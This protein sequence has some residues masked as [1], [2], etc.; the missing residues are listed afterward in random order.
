MIIHDRYRSDEF[1]GAKLPKLKGHV[2]VSLHNCRTGKNEVWEGDN[3]VTNAVRD[4]FAL[5][6]LGGIDHSKLLPLYQSYFG[7]I[8]CYDTLHTLNAD[9]YY[10]QAGHGLV[11]H[12]GDIAPSTAA[13]IQED[14]TRGAPLSVDVSNDNSVTMTWEWGSEQGN[15][16]INS[17]SLTHKDTGNAGLGVNSSAF[18]AFN[19]YLDITSASLTALPLSLNGANNV[20]LKYDDAHCLYFHIGEPSDYYNNHT[21]FA[22]QKITVYKRNLAF[23]KAGLYQNINPS[24]AHEDS[25]TVTTSVN[26]YANPA[27][28]FDYTN[29]KLWLFTN[30]TGA[31]NGYDGTPYSS[32]VVYYSVIDCVNKTEDSHGTITSDTADLAPLCWGADTAFSWDDSRRYMTNLIKQGNYVFFPKTTGI[33][34]NAGAA[35]M[36]WK[37]YRAINI[38][39]SQTYKDISFSDTLVYPACMGMDGGGLIVSPGRII[40]GTTGYTCTSPFTAPSDPQTASQSSS[41]SFATPDKPSS[42]VMAIG[43]GNEGS[44]RPRYIFANKMLNTTLFNLDSPVVKNTSKSLNI[45]YTLTEA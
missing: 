12:A 39:N 13:I 4:I 26:F 45:Q 6:F 22:T 2:K 36:N 17:I 29:K 7:G 21:S 42:F 14:L 5:N 31:A 37:G 30:L 38:T 27:Y 3:I 15:G 8:L 11:A 33:S 43:N 23:Q 1:S 40:R 41:W 28:Y 25:F 10:P 24:T 32:S 18:K 19:P 35:Q 44:T 20:F 34:S 9:N 16:T